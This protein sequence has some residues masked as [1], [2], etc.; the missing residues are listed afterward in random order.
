[1]LQKNINEKKVIFMGPGNSD[2]CHGKCHGKSWNFVLE[3]LY[4]PCLRQ[5]TY[6]LKVKQNVL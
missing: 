5:V 2:C 3:K 6:K 1:M 4:E